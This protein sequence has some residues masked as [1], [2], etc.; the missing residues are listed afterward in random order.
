M[1]IKKCILFKSVRPMRNGK[2]NPKDYPYW[3]ELRIL[4]SE[5]YNVS[6]VDEIIQL[7]ELKELLLEADLIICTDS[8]IQHYCWSIGKQ[9]VVIFGKSD[10]LVFGHQENINLLK[11]RDSLRPNQFDIWENEAYDINVF[12]NAQEI[13]GEINNG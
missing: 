11:S 12:V 5:K 2:R 4:L 13:L 3:D 6:E 7:K 10:P 8:F 1:P 9:C